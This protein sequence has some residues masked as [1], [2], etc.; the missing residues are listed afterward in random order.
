MPE[1]ERT[2]VSYALRHNKNVQF[3][4]AILSEG[5]FAVELREV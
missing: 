4:E 3:K 5:A 2:M 1:A